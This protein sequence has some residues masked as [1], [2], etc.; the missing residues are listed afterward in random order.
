MNIIGL[1]SLSIFFLLLL[2]FKRIIKLSN[3]FK[4]S[5]WN[6]YFKNIMHNK[7]YIICI[8]KYH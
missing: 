5:A 7:F 3:I 4:L 1:G 2:I 6:F 8:K